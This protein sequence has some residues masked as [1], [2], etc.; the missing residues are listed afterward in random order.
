MIVIPSISRTVP[1]WRVYVG[2]AG[3]VARIAHFSAKV[4]AE[5]EA[6]RLRQKYPDPA[7]EFWASNV[8]ARPN[9]RWAE[10]EPRLKTTGPAKEIFGGSSREVADRRVSHA[11]R[12]AILET[13][14]NTRVDLTVPCLLYT[15][16]ELMDHISGQFK[17]GMT[18]QN[19]SSEW[20]I[21]HIE[22]RALFDMRDPLQLTKC[23]ALSNLQPL[24]SW[25]NNSKGTE[26]RRLIQA[27]RGS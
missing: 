27:R 21:D 23:W 25:E 22:P 5:A 26:D 16:H 2:Y 13:A 17:P 15:I 19:Y 18:W 3:R 14:A 6:R 12:N 1:R 24:W 4:L 10:I 20:V 8:T 11:V 7:A 9:G